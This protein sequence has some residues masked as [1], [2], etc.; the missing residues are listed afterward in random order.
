MENALTWSRTTATDHT[1]R[2]QQ[3]TVSPQ[4]SI[5][6]HYMAALSQTA[7]SPLAPT[8]SAMLHTKKK[9]DVSMP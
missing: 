8:F 3:A 1:H 6:G 9:I 7:R 5:Y 4:G 2:D